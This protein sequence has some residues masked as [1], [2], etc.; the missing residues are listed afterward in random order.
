MACSVI[1][2]DG[3]AASGKSTVA[4]EVAARLGYAWVNS[5]A[6]YRALTWWM[7][8]EGRDVREDRLASIEARANFDGTEARL[9]VDGM[10]VRQHLRDPEV[11]RHVSPVS[12]LPIVRAI[13][14]RELRAIAAGRDCVIEGRDIG[15]CV[16]PETPF[17][18]Y[19]DA[20][21][22]ERERRRREQGESD[23]IL[24]RDRLDTGRTVAPLEPAPDALHLDTTC[25]S[26]E[27]VV[28]RI[29]AAIAAPRAG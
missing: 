11:N 25:L 23:S 2:I 15:T 9:L 13:V 26:I 4:R 12:Q 19:I 16:F 18:F 29:L 27:E 10:D 22:E 5:G 20:S 8:R 3:P 14:G 17:K 28:R 1:A 7:L 21:P 24:E 6:F